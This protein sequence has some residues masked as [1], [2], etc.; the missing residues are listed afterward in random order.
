MEIE[1]LY[2]NDLNL[3]KLNNKSGIYKL[4]AGGHI[5]IG[6]S[7]NLY[8]RLYEHKNDLI[9]H[10][11]SNNFLQKVFDKEGIQN[12]KIDIIEFCDSKIRIERE[13]YWIKK[14]NADM[15]LQDPISHE[16]SE[17]SKRKLSNSI[18]KGLKDGKYKKKYDFCEIEAYD[19]FGN[20]IKSFKSKEEASKEFNFTIKEVQSLAS[21]YRKGSSKN[22]I[23]LRYAIS[24]VPIQKFDINSN[25]IGNHY[26]FF[27]I[28]ENGNEKF[29]FSSVKDCWKFFGEHA[30]LSEIKIIPKPRYLLKKNYSGKRGKQNSVN[31]ET[32]INGQS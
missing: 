20:F 17:E 24:S 21:G 12:F 23:R 29:A 4:S 26:V 2:F 5:Y 31:L 15:N 28:D 6:S 22:G 25:F 19:Y 13:S 11:H 1:N 32:S 16:L 14:L 8:Q 7:K 18:K 30:N 9:K 27:Y 10:K 3:K